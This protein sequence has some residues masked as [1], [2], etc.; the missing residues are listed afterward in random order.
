M[1]MIA[2]LVLA[3]FA[4]AVQASEPAPPIVVL[5]SW[6]GM[7]HDFPDR[8]EYPGLARMARDG[9][10]AAGLVPVYPSNTFPGHVSL[11]T[12]TWPDRHGIVDNHFLARTR[13]EYR[14]EADADWLLAEPL[15]I[16]AERQGVP[17]A[18][19]FWVGSESDWRGLGTDGR[20]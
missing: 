20:R 14:Y 9:A 1:R 4:V 6:D 18:T 16:A 10:R 2:G 15:W 19:Y 5:L 8:G 11:A 17:T 3:L 13:G 12:G 7:R